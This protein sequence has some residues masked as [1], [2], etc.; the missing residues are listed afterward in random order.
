M[1]SKQPGELGGSGA[2]EVFGEAPA[3]AEPS[4]GTLDDPAPRQELEAFDPSG[5]STISIVRGPQP[6]SALT[7]CLPR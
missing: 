1:G 7:S 3:S 6:E 5:R 2:F 4:K